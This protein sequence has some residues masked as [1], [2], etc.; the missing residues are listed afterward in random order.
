MQLLYR[1]YSLG[2][3]YKKEVYRHAIHLDMNVVIGLLAYV[4]HNLDGVKQHQL[5][6]EY[7]STC[8]VAEHSDE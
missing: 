5:T 7:C 8:E 1:G 3:G 4:V 6:N 2:S